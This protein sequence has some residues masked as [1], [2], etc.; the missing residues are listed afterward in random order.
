ME[1]QSRARGYAFLLGVLRSQQ[2]DPLCSKCS[3]YANTLR[4]ALEELTGFEEEQG[5]AI[6]QLPPEL[7]KLLAY[8]REELSRLEP[9]AEPQGQKKAGNCRLPQGVC[10]IKASLTLVRGL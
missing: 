3:A 5:P 10:F 6:A 2:G 4:V 1:P 7:A 8:A 9:P